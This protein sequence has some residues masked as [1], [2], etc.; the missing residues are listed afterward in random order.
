MISLQIEPGISV[1]GIGQRLL[2]LGDVSV[3]RQLQH[4]HASRGC[5][6]ANVSSVVQINSIDTKLGVQVFEAK[7]W[8]PV[9]SCYE[10][11]KLFFLIVW[12]AL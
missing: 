1:Y 6:E 8:W 4:V 5:G 12:K 7:Q 9:G 3:V 2:E 10:H 11:Q